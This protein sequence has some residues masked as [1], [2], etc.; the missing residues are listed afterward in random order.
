MAVAPWAQ[1]VGIFLVALNFAFLRA[2]HLS[3]FLSVVVGVEEDHPVC[4]DS[5]SCPRLFAE[6]PTLHDDCV[7]DP[8]NPLCVV[9]CTDHPTPETLRRR[10][11]RNE[12]IWPA[13]DSKG[14]WVPNRT[15]NNYTLVDQYTWHEDP[16]YRDACT[17]FRD[18]NISNIKV[19]GD[20][21]MRQMWQGL[22]ILLFDEPEYDFRVMG[23]NC[24]GSDSFWTRKCNPRRAKGQGVELPV[25]DGSILLQFQTHTPQNQHEPDLEPARNATGRTLLLYGVGNHPPNGD[26]SP[27]GRLGILNVTAWKFWHW[28][29]F[30]DSFFGSDNMT[31]IWVPPHFKMSINGMEESNERALRF[32]H[33]SSEFFASHGVP[34]LNTYSL[35]QG[36]VPHLCR[37]CEY[38]ED[39]KDVAPSSQCT[40]HS[41]V[42]GEP[43]VETWDGYHYARTVNYWKAHLL[44][45][46]LYR[47]APL[48]E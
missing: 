35:T 40:Y 48:Q 21:L 4:D 46:H 28:D 41:R 44:L 33:E 42:T 7:Q 6:H 43:T 3:G 9:K 1:R 8:R 17:V 38:P 16:T 14:L 23:R 13:L 45:E 30:P 11:K 27:H 34:T 37:S 22:T 31:V 39:P 20:S 47:F 25:C 19:V 5:R 12:H 2:L 24:R 26:H 32:F 18:R 15:P 36:A 29:K 10:H